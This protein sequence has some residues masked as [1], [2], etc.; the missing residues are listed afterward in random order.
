MLTLNEVTDNHIAVL[1]ANGTL[2]KEDVE[3]VKP[4]LEEALVRPDP[5]RFYIELDDFTGMDMAAAKE[6]LRFDLKHKD[7][8]GKTAIVGEKRWQEWATRFSDLVF[9]APLRFFDKE[10]SNE[11]WRWVNS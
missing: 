2:T 6:D 1:R 10:Q 11:A 5:L 4:M 3:H 7:Q 8:Y 9:D